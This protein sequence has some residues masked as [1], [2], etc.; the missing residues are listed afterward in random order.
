M[1]VETGVV[2]IAVPRCE[3]SSDNFNRSV[4]AEIIKIR[5]Y[6]KIIYEKFT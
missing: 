2:N 3:G 1:I 4:Q 5:N 6:E